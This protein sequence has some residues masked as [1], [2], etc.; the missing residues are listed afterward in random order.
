MRHVRLLLFPDAPTEHE[1]KELFCMIQDYVQTN[2]VGIDLN[3]N[4][5]K[6]SKMNMMMN[7]D[8]SGGLYQ[9]NSLDRPVKLGRETSRPCSDWQYRHLVHK[10]GGDVLAAVAATHSGVPQQDP[11]G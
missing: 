8:G 9:E 6:A 10:S 7:N 4:L 5:V 2:I 1:Q 3:P 11:I